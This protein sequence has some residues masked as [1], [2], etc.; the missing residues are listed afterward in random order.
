[1]NSSGFLTPWAPRDTPGTPHSLPCFWIQWLWVLTEVRR[2]VIFNRN[3]CFEKEKMHKWSRNPP[4]L[5]PTPP[6]RQPPE[7]R[8]HARQGTVTRRMGKSGKMM[9]FWLLHSSSCQ[10]V[11]SSFCDPWGVVHQTSCKNKSLWCTEGPGRRGE[12]DPCPL[13]SVHQA[14]Q[15]TSVSREAKPRFALYPSARFPGD[16]DLRE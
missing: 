11:S 5:P 1:M 15:G 16:G 9:V 2:V 8:G 13:F 7:I 14:H 12:V 6:P 10:V 3:G 4:P